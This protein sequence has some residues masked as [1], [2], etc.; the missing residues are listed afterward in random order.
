[1]F[2]NVY[3]LLAVLSVLSFLLAGAVA[4]ASAAPWRDKV[5]PWVLSTASEGRHRVPGFSHPARR[6]SARQMRYRPSWKRVHMCIR[7]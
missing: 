6:I 4:P 3:K 1:M 7:P 2:K 5:D